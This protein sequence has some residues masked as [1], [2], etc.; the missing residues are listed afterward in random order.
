MHTRQEY[1][2]GTV[3]H[4]EYYGQFVTDG[5]KE[6]VKHTFGVVRL[7]TAFSEDE[8]FN[9]ISLDKWDNLG[10][11]IQGSASAQVKEVGDFISKAGLVCILKEAARQVVEENQ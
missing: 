8:H 4:R 10:I 7:S 5:T 3:T 6:L 9:N 2:N 11:L 1:M